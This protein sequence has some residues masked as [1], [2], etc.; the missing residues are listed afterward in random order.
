MSS[1]EHTFGE[2][3]ERVDVSRAVAKIQLLGMDAVTNSAVVEVDVAHALSACAL[4]PVDRS[5][6]VVLEAGGAGGVRGV[7]VITAVT[8]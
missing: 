3:V 7:H 8:K 5:L 6:V 2:D 4:W 1:I